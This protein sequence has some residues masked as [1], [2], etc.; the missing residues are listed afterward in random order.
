MNL[1]NSTQGHDG[2]KINLIRET[3]VYIIRPITHIFSLSLQSGIVPQDLKIIKVIPIFK[4][5]NTKDFVNYRPITIL[6]SVSKILEKLI[7][8][9]ISK[10]LAVNN[11]LYDHQYGFR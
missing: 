4:T 1:K 7:H 11:I 5:G 8:T 10:H 2:V 6:N 3:I 9:R